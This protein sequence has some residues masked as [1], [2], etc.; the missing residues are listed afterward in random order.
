MPPVT[1]W[2]GL[3][4]APYAFGRS[5]ASYT[6]TGDY[7]STTA[8]FPSSGTN[9]GGHWAPLIVQT[10]SRGLGFQTWGVGD[11]NMAGTG[12]PGGLMGFYRRA[13]LALGR[14]IPTI[15]ANFNQPGSDP[16]TYMA[17][18]ANI[19]DA[20]RPSGLVMFP[21]SFNGGAAT[22]TKLDTDW[23]AGMLLAERVQRQ[24]GVPVLMGYPPRPA[25]TADQDAIRLQSL[26]RIAAA[27]ANGMRGVDTNAVIA[28]PGAP[29]TWAPGMSDV[30]EMHYSGD[31]HAVVGDALI[32]ELAEA[33]GIY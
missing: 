5:W 12:S 29:Q 1:T 4:P 26:Q 17:N 9:F 33:F 2:L 30:A 19:L 13:T 3:T 6:S 31:G 15:G 25:M 27:R 14:R 23:A 21:F 22:Q 20:V 16:P 7:V 24:G 11:S 8:G 32:P 28:V 18:V 10:F